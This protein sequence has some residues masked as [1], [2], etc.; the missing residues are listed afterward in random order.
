MKTRNNISLNK[1]NQL[2]QN[3]NSIL[4]TSHINPDGDGIGSE[5]GLYHYLNDIGKDCKIINTSPI[6]E[7]FK[8]LDQDSVTL[9]Y[10]SDYNQWIE[11][12]DLIIILDI[13]DIKRVGPMK[14]LFSKDSISICIDHHPVRS[15]EDYSYICVDTNEPSTGSIIYKYLLQANTSKQLP[16]KIAVPLYVA[17]FTDTGSFRYSNTNFEAHEMAA[18]LIK[19]GVKPHEIQT[20]VYESRSIS[21][22]RL[23]GMIIDNLNFEL[24]GKFVWFVITSEMMENSRISPSEIDG[25]TDFARTINNVEIAC[26][27]LE[28]PDQEV[29]INFRSKGK[30]AVNDVAAKFK[31]GGHPFAAGAIVENTSCMD[32][33]N[34]ILQEMK[35]KIEEV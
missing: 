33:K 13:G 18:D 30:Y 24:N 12:V 25:F 32:V 14:E 21:Q 35:I 31:G 11:N 1:L 28:L 3:A 15:S 16:L 9:T 29:R 5:L 26:M 23:L 6:P 8:F 2:I 20:R 22:V 17:L 27:I 10:S 34:I 7:L 4:L 19:S